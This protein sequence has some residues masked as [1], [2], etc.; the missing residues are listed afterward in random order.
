[1]IIIGKTIV[2]LCNLFN[3][4]DSREQTTKTSVKAG[5]FVQDVNVYGFRLRV[6]LNGLVER[7]S[8]ILD[9]YFWLIKQIEC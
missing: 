8:G 1:M 7:P 4:F 3:Y 9:L 5:V 2:I 6:G